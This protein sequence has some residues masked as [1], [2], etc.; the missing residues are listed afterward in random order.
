MDYFIL[1]K[2]FLMDKTITVG[3]KLLVNELVLSFWALKKCAKAQSNLM[4]LSKVIAVTDDDN[5][6]R[7]TNTIPKTIF[8]HSG[9]LKTWR[10]DEKRGGQIL[11]KSNTFSDENV[12]NFSTNYFSPRLILF[13]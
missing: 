8:S 1:L 4:I 13:F 2:P 6:N 9:C 5:D 12:K 10:F 3:Q 7:K 11:H